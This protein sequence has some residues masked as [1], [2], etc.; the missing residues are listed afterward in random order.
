MQIATE[1]LHSLPSGASFTAKE[2]RANIDIRREGD[3]IVITAVCDSLQ[4][5]V[6]KLYAELDRTRIRNDTQVV[7]TK[8]SVSPV[9]IFCYGCFTGLLLTIIL[10]LLIKN[11]VK[12]G[13]SK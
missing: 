7:E 1:T 4:R 2:G 6:E 11:F 8:K 3:S 10:L 9:R 12:Y 13:T 5:E